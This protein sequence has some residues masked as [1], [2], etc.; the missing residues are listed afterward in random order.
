MAC[1]LAEQVYYEV[2]YDTSLEWQA[3]YILPINLATS[4][5]RA[6]GD[7]RLYGKS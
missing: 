5:T 7:C 2:A 4:N 6:H 1:R 3:Q